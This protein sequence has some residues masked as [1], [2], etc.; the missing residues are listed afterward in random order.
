[1]KIHNI[2]ELKFLR[3]ILKQ[4]FLANGFDYSFGFSDTDTLIMEIQQNAPD[5]IIVQESYSDRN[6]AEMVSAFRMAGISQDIFVILFEDNPRSDGYKRL[7]Q[8]KKLHIIN[9]QEFPLILKNF[10]AARALPSGAM[11]EYHEESKKILVVDDSQMIHEIIASKLGARYDLFHAMNAETA[12]EMYNR[13][14]PD[15]ILTDIEMPGMSA[16]NSAA[17][18]NSKPQTV[19]TRKS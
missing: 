14:L 1:M 12:L 2:V 8:Y 3:T 7:R 17:N 18:Q 11:L 6:T 10:F 5:F 16:L 9:K 15:L 13:V 19:H 4:F